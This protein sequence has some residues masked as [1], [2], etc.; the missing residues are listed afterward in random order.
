MT[1][2]RPVVCCDLDGVVWPIIALA[3]VMQARGGGSI[4]ISILPR[5]AAGPAFSG[6]VPMM[7]PWLEMNV[8]GSREMVRMSS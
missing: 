4:V 8:A 2:D 3:K 7:M 6:V 5:P 1:A